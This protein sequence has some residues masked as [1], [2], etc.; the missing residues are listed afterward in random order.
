MCVCVSISVCG[1][2]TKLGNV[3]T[4]VETTTNTAS[5]FNNIYNDGHFDEP[6]WQQTKNKQTNG[7]TTEK[8]RKYR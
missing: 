1:F 7:K 2:V 4:S 8:K 5:T 6:Q 3:P